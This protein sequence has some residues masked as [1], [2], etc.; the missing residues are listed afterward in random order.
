MA[1]QK[2]T[3]TLGHYNWLSRREEILSKTARE[4]RVDAI[5]LEEKIEILENHIQSLETEREWLKSDARVG[6]E[7]I[8]ALNKTHDIVRR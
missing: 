4:L 8:A 1:Q 3:I 7:L 5:R 6:Q 2:V